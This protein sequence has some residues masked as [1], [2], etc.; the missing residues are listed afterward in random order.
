[1]SAVSKASTFSVLFLQ[2][3]KNTF[4]ILLVMDAVVRFLNVTFKAVVLSVSRE[5]WEEH[6]VTV[7]L[8]K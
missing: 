4:T 1:M 7:S 3:L 8:C 6:W 2:N 5:R